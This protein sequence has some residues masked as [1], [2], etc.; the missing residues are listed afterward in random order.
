MTGFELNIG[1]I[2][3]RRRIAVVVAVV[4]AVVVGG[5]LARAWPRDVG[6]AFEV[7]PAVTELDV[8]YVQSGVAVT[9][10]RF[11]GFTGET[12]IFRH[13]ARLRPGRYQVFITL[14]G[15]DGSAIEEVRT[16]AVPTAGRTRFDLK[17]VT[18]PS[19]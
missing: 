17:T 18:E 9:S 11:G 10:V 19:E 5:Q 1:S 2:A 13:Q 3:T 4:G 8:D 15:H 16:L 7:G 14:Y 6:V 12:G